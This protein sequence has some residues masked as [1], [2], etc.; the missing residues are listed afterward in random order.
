M[1]SVS[2]LPHEH[3]IWENTVFLFWERAAVSVGEFFPVW[4]CTAHGNSSEVPNF[5]DIMPDALRWSRY[6]SRRHK[7]GVNGPRF[8]QPEAF[9]HAQAVETLSPMK[10]ATKDGDRWTA[11][12]LSAKYDCDNETNQPPT[13]PQKEPQVTVKACRGTEAQAMRRW[14]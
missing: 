4:D 3:L 14:K 12:T 13:T 8:N 10:P 9:P 5:Q 7:C 1:F 11:E 6:D 2:I